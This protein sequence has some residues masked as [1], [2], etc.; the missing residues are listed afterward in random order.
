MGERCG[1]E[2]WERGVGG[3]WAGCRAFSAG[4]G[5]LSWIWH[6]AVSGV[7]VERFWG[8]VLRAKGAWD[9]YWVCSHY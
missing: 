4:A 7:A 9:G 3:V 5:C 8:V 1:S 2:V 6:A